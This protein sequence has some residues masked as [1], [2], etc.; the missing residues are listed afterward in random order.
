MEILF[1]IETFNVSKSTNWITAE[2]QKHFFLN[3]A[4]LIE[5]LNLWKIQRSVY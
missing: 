4:T 3:F 1:Q 2:F 5:I